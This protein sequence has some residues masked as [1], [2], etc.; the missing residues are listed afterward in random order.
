MT[1]PRTL[2]RPANKRERMPNKLNKAIRFF[3]TEEQFTKIATAARGAGLKPAAFARMHVLNA[4]R[5]WKN[6]VDTVEFEG[7]DEKW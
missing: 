3:L 6:L 5:K 2:Q 4:T 7:K 1:P